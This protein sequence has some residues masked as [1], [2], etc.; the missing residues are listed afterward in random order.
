MSAR[1]KADVVMDPLQDLQASIEAL[2]LQADDPMLA[3]MA[4][5]SNKISLMSVAQSFIVTQNK[6]LLAADRKSQVDSQN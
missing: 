5:L 4:L 1:D 6:T 3:V 2:N